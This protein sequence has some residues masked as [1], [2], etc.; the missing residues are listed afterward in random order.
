MVGVAAGVGLALNVPGRLLRTLIGMIIVGAGVVIL[1]LRNWSVRYRGPA[2]ALLGVLAS[3]NKAV[4]GGGYGPL[5]TSG[6]IVS[7]VEGRAAIGITSLAEGVTCM[8]AGG[9]Y[10][11]SGPPLDLSLVAVVSCGALLA[12]PATAQVVRRTS[13]RR[14]KLVIGLL[15]LFMGGLTLFK[16]WVL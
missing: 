9:L 16:T 5:L 8:V 3:F 7:G 15:T 4:S 13:E 14:L 10:L 6:Q 11:A 1:V 12:V 2:I